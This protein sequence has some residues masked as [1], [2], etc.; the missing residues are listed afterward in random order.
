MD[1][2][3]KVITYCFHSK[4]FNKLYITNYN[5]SLR[6]RERESK[7]MFV[8]FHYIGSQ[9]QPPAP[10]QLDDRKSGPAARLF[11]ARLEKRGFH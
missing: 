2:L 11:A 7:V 6:E 3:Y 5:F 1:F 10:F 8:I 4:Q 9:G